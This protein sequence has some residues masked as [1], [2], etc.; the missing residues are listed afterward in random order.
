MNNKSSPTVNTLEI[1]PTDLQNNILLGLINL[2]S[3]AAVSDGVDDDWLVGLGARLLE[4]FRTF[5][6]QNIT[7]GINEINAQKVFKD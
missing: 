1:D 6:E 7:I 4:E 2:P 5:K 3:Q